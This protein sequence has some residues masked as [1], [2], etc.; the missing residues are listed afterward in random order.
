VN[1]HGGVFSTILG[2]KDKLCRSHFQSG[3]LFGWRLFVIAAGG[4]SPLLPGI[5]DDMVSSGCE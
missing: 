2:L 5:I 3:G 1:E 4:L